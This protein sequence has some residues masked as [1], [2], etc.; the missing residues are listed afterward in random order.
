M[1]TKIENAARSGYDVASKVADTINFE[2]ISLARKKYSLRR[3]RA[4]ILPD[5]SDLFQ[6]PAW[7]ILLDLFIAAETN[8]EISVSSACIASGVP[9]TTALRAIGVMERRG[10]LKGGSD[11]FDA[12]RRFV[13]LSDSMREQMRTLLT[14]W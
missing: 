11:P 1:Q 9:S 13:S 3:R 2:L 7:D 10:V 4:N 6:D 12:R 8:A 14:L 5:V